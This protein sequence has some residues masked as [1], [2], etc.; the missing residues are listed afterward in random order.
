MLSVSCAAMGQQY[1]VSTIAGGAPPITPVPGSSISVGQPSG[2]AVDVSGSVYFTGLDCVFRLDQTGVL[3]RV[4]GNS[5]SGYSGDGGPAINAE[6]Y[7]PYGVAVDNEGN[8]YIADEGNG[9]I[10]KVLP[11]GIII[12][13]AGNGIQ[14]FAGD[15]GP[16]VTAELDTPVG[17]AT[18][19]AGNLYI[20]DLLNNRI[21]RVSPDGKISTVA[22]NGI[23]GYMGGYS[24]DGGQATS[25]QLNEPTGVAVDGNGNI[26]VADTNNNRIRKISLDGIISTVAGGGSVS[27]S[28]GALA[29]NAVL[30]GPQSVT[31][32]LA[33]NLYIADA[34][35]IRKVLPSGTIAIVAGGGSL[36]PGDDGPAIDATLSDPR[37]VAADYDGNL[38][39]AD[40]GHYRVREV[41]LSGTISTVAGTGTQTDSANGTNA[42]ETP[43]DSVGSVALDGAGNLYIAGGSD[44]LVRKLSANGV[45]SVVAGGGSAMPGDGGA[46]T[47]AELNFPLGV[48]V[49]NAG[50]LYIA[51]NANCR[52]RK[53]SP[54]G[55]I[56]TV[57]GNGTNGY[58]GDGGPATLAQ[59]G[60]PNGVAVDLNGNIY[61]V[62]GAHSRIRK[63]SGD[64]IIT[65]VAGNGTEGFS[66]DGGPAVAA[67]LDYPISVAVDSVGNLF[68]SEG[69]RIREVSTQ[70]IITTV[71]GNGIQGF[72]GDGG[73][74]IGAELNFA[75]T[76]APDI[77]GNLFIADA[78]NQ[79]IRTVSSAG[80]INTV[81]GTGTS[82]Y[83]G[84]GGLATNA[85]FNMP[86]GIAVDSRGRIYVGDSDNDAIRLLQPANYKVLISSVLDA[87]SES[88]I[89]VSPG[90]IVDIYGSGLG[91]QSLAINQ[92]S[93][94]AFGAAVGG[95]SV[96]FN[97][98]AAPMIYASS[99]QAAAIA[100]YELSGMAT[101]QVT[102]TSQNGA[103]PSFE[104]ALAAASPSF[105]SANGTGAGQA[106]AV[107][108]D[109]SLN[110]AA[111]PIGVGG[112]ISFYLTGE[113]QTS[114]GG[115][116]GALALTQP[117]PA[118]VLPVQVAVGGIPAAPLYA[119]AAPTEVAGLMQVVVQIPPGVQ[120]GGYVPVTVSVGR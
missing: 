37:A 41:T 76:V 31:L 5:R 104:V 17:V 96:S 101:A 78:A 97:G 48:A 99:T 65:T 4:A 88:A 38:Y 16:A 45:I 50:N 79:R 36:N 94:G 90:K 73:P 57:A 74:A 53:V 64:G 44:N 62:D 58:S 84:D 52:I 59:I 27:A 81:A 87:A 40:T 70:G 112:Y 15:G 8:I 108:G 60:Q 29:T 100:P 110:D 119:G 56:T 51:D 106:A 98:I 82:G 14:G 86:F 116:D 77:A 105:F 117:Y 10:R 2:V 111:H 19:G 43:L 46:A 23:A 80:I 103:S 18:D 71:V 85:Q 115:K 114:P 55:T 7:D 75:S 113:G 95:T 120:P 39:I 20:A 28:D 42:A 54:N 68:I 24:G 21:R 102:V 25:A 92:P 34:F 66:G 118:P 69:L 26:F 35:V 93:S 22:G 3:T 32:D 11:N 89:A 33:G 67:Q 109:G 47:D 83:S 63:V 12:T 13:V 6:L 49:D 91:P 30:A 72:S 107:N 9:R 61:I 1:V